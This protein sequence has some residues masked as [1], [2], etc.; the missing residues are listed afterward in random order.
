MT[1]Q[2]FNRAMGAVIRQQRLTRGLTMEAVAKQLGFSYQQQSK[3]EHGQNACTAHLTAKYAALFGISI[4]VFYEIAETQQNT[5]PTP[6]EN[7]GFL[8]ARYVS[9]IADE[10]LRGAVVDFTRKLAYQG[11]EA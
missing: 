10:K 8:A 2:Q 7:D 6:T 4:A 3:Y 11:G 5:E 1:P 9:R